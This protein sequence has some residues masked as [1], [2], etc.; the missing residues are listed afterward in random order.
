M[1]ISVGAKSTPITFF[2]GDFNAE[3]W[4]S[5]L[6]SKDPSYATI[7]FGKSQILTGGTPDAYLYMW[8]GHNYIYSSGVVFY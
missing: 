4:E 5:F 8:H 2:D 1:L 3:D 7:E 6:A